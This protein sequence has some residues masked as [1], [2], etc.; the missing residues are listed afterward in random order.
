VY[1][2]Q[3]VRKAISLLSAALVLSTLSEADN[4]LIRGA[5]VFDG[6]RMLGIQ[7]VLIESAR[8]LRIASKLKSP[9]KT[10]VI[11][12]KAARCSRVF[13]IPIST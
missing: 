11:N 13:L 5:R 9:K 2:S 10:H 7:N 6:E 3:I 12:A 8:I 1:T 4:T